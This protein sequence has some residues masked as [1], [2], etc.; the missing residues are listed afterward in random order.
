MKK[1]LI[2]F[3]LVA[4]TQFVHGQQ[5]NRF[6]MGMDMGLAFPNGGGLGLL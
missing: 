2:I 6:R 1:L 4:A 5:K 3:F